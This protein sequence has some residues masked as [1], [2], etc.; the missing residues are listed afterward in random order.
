MRN[1][2]SE[3]PNGFLFFF[4]F[5]YVGS[6]RVHVLRCVYIEKTG[7]VC[8][9]LPQFQYKIRFFTVLFILF[10]LHNTFCN[11]FGFYC[12]PHVREL[13]K[14]FYFGVSMFPRFDARKKCVLFFKFVETFSNKTSAIFIH[15]VPLI[16]RQEQIVFRR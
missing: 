14:A 3:F 15:R 11:S 5:I 6:T 1:I 13:K 12:P 10:N 9:F 4:H 2:T 16:F 7:F 8:F